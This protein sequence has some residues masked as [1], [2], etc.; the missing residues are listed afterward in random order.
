MVSQSKALTTYNNWFDIFRAISE[1]CAFL[2]DKIRVID[3]GGVFTSGSV[4]RAFIVEFVGYVGQPPSLKIIPDED[5]PLKGKNIKITHDV[6]VKFGK[7]LWYEPVPFEMLRTYETK[8]Q[9][10]VN[11]NDMPAVCKN[12][13]CDFTYT[14]PVGEITAFTYDTASKVVVLTGTA[15][16]EKQTDIQKIMF[17]LTECKIDSAK[18]S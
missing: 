8:P 13:T 9:V 7:N 15:F 3:K 12:L 1:H 17:A 11:V 5:T 2:R 6:P 14:T 18:Y 4:G 10:I 16:P